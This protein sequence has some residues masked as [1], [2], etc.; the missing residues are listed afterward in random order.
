LTTI[1]TWYIINYGILHLTEGCHNYSWDFRNKFVK[2]LR[3]YE[4]KIMNYQ[5]TGQISGHSKPVVEQRISINL[6]KFKKQRLVK[7]TMLNLNWEINGISTFKAKVYVQEDSL[8]IAHLCD[9][10]IIKQRIEISSTA[11]HFGGNRK[12]L[13]CPVCGTR[14]MNLYFNE[15]RNLF[16]CRDCNNLGYLSQKQNPSNRLILNAQ[17]LRRKISAGFTAIENKPLNMHWETFNHIKYKIYDFEIQGNNL[18]MQW[19]NGRLAK[20]LGIP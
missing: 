17:K 4:V 15:N 20:Q 2:S 7:D 16:L 13:S 8:L 1:D 14:R 11:C 3:Y 12:W 19:A 10:E 18:F 5:E 9:G 6:S